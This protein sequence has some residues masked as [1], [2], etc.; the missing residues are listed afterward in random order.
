MTSI[1][2][3][4]GGGREGSLFSLPVRPPVISESGPVLKT[5]LPNTVTSGFRTSAWELGGGRAGAHSQ[6]IPGYALPITLAGLQHVLGRGLRFIIY[7]FGNL[8]LM[9]R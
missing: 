5:L 8:L 4:R 1:L 6:S 7:L 2:R 3:A 9:N